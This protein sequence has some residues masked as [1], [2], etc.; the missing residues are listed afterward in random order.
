MSAEFNAVK[1][2]VFLDDIAGLGAKS[3]ISP[4][5]LLAAVLMSWPVATVG[6][7]DSSGSMRREYWKNLYNIT[8]SNSDPG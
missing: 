3:S 2:Q 4:G 5:S 1:S 6:V 7:D 8:E